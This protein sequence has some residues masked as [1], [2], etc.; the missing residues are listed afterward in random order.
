MRKRRKRQVS[1]PI[2]TAF[3]LSAMGLLM[4]ILAEYEPPL[5]AQIPKPP[6]LRNV[7]GYMMPMMNEI[8]EV[9]RGSGEKPEAPIEGK[10]RAGKILVD[11]MCVVPVDELSLGMHKAT[12][13]ALNSIVNTTDYFTPAEQQVD[14]RIRPIMVKIREALADFNPDIGKYKGDNLAEVRA[15]VLAEYVPLRTLKSL[16]SGRGDPGGVLFSENLFLKMAGDMETLINVTFA[17]NRFHKSD[18]AAF[19][20]FSAAA[21]SLVS[22]IPLWPWQSDGVIAAKLAIRRQTERLRYEPI[23]ADQIPEELKAWD[24]RMEGIGNEAK[25][26]MQ[27]NGDSKEAIDDVQA[28]FKVALP[29]VRES[30]KK[31]L[32]AASVHDITKDRDAEWKTFHDA[33]ADDTLGLP[34]ATMFVKMSAY[35]HEKKPQ[36]LI[37]ELYKN[38]RLAVSK[39]L[40]PIFERLTDEAVKISLLDSNWPFVPAIRDKTLETTLE[41]IRTAYNQFTSSIN[42]GGGWDPLVLEHQVDQILAT[43]RIPLPYRDPVKLKISL[44]AV[45]LELETM[46]MLVDELNRLEF[47]GG[48]AHVKKLPEFLATAHMELGKYEKDPMSWHARGR[49]PELASDRGKLCKP[50]TPDGRSYACTSRWCIDN[51]CANFDQVWEKTFGRPPRQLEAALANAKEQIHACV[52]GM[53]R[54]TLTNPNVSETADLRVALLTLMDFMQRRLVPGLLNLPNVKSYIVTAADSLR[55]IA[56]QLHQNLNIE[57]S[58]YEVSAEVA[59]GKVGDDRFKLPVAHLMPDADAPNALRQVQSNAFLLL[60]IAQAD[61]AT[62]SDDAAAKPSPKVQA[63]YDELIGL[64][65]KVRDKGQEIFKVA[66]G[67][68]GRRPPPRDVQ[69]PGLWHDREAPVL[70]IAMMEKEFND[71]AALIRAVDVNAATNGTKIPRARID[72]VIGILKNTQDYLLGWGPKDQVGRFINPGVVGNYQE[73]QAGIASSPPIALHRFGNAERDTQTAVRLLKKAAYTIRAADIASR[74]TPDTLPVYACPPKADK[75]EYKTVGEF[76]K[77]EF[78][79]NG[80][81]DRIVSLVENLTLRDHCSTLFCGAKTGYCLFKDPAKASCAAP[82]S[83]DECDVGNGDRYIYSQ[84]VCRAS[85]KANR[86]PVGYCCWPETVTASCR[87]DLTT[88]DACSTRLPDETFFF[89]PADES[90]TNG[91]KL[92][93]DTCKIG[94]PSCDPSVAAIFGGIETTPPPPPVVEAKPVVKPV[95]AKPGVAPGKPP[96]INRPGERTLSHPH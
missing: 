79:P 36:S 25:E 45:K 2:A 69:D 38:Q 85:L 33:L 92:A 17:P 60:Q 95:P 35:A 39:A 34:V 8:D 83:R 82:I 72:E 10:C 31:Y 23:F 74:L 65:Y 15:A 7:V 91:E 70:K 40:E 80:P 52:A 62:V 78:T 11:G 75:C 1:G 5:Q 18:S 47:D 43:I 14:G 53:T 57:L 86:Q 76:K 42:A 89:Y 16:P 41:E 44:D 54:F 49:D 24:S 48:C 12:V 46:Q 96:V 50:D 67:Q 68:L 19:K 9:I 4:A 29:K 93:L 73:G 88:K 37:R 90:R 64:S 77:A 26:M 71:L 84:T 32:D 27:K 51:K 66:D 30:F 59:K 21:Q 63:L 87:G 58:P 61:L 20:R 94:Y 28:K 56:D 55:P 6:N 22:D 81:S 3:A 13:D